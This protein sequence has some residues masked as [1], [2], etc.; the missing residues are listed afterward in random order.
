MRILVCGGRAYS[1]RNFIFDSLDRFRSE[2]AVD[3]IIT[4]AA[5]SKNNNR[6]PYQFTGAD[7]IAIEWAMSRQIPFV[8]MP[9]QWNKLG[10][11]AG[12]AR[13][14]QM[15][16]WWSPQRCIAFPGDNGTKDMMRRCREI[17]IPVIEYGWTAI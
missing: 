12:P 15:L 11:K 3:V 1:D 8:G 4:G 9:A 10:D 5:R 7:W 14:Q 16:D 13:N 6:S 17:N 2:N